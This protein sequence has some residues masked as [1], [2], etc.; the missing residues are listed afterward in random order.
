MP[1][2]MQTMADQIAVTAI[3]ANGRATQLFGQ[4]DYDRK[5]WIYSPSAGVFFS[6]SPITRAAAGF[7]LPA[8]RVVQFD[9]PARCELYGISAGGTIQV[10]RY[11][12]TVMPTI[13]EAVESLLQALLAKLR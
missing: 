5:V 13:G 3:G 12:S 10:S 2:L 9:L 8:N 6:H 11:S 4:V 1:R 7:A